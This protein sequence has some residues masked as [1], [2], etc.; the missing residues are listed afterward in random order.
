MNSKRVGDVCCES[1]GESVMN[2][3]VNMIDISG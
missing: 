2:P 3:L 1:I